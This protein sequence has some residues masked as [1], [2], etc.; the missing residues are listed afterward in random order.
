MSTKVDLKRFKEVYCTTLTPNERKDGYH[1][2]LPIDN[3]EELE[4]YKS[5]LI[6][7]IQYTSILI[8]EKSF[9]DTVE[10]G[11]TINYLADILEQLNTFSE[12]EGIT[13][14]LRE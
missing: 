3:Y 9:I 6:K 10:A 4:C 11:F 5:Y 14:L 2:K 8:Q 7:A 13:K 12:M 1:V